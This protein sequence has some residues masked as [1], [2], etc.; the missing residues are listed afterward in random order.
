MKYVIKFII[1]F[2]L[3]FM[4]TKSRR[5]KYERKHQWS[6]C[7]RYICCRGDS[8]DRL[9]RDIERP[10]KK[11]QNSL[12]VG[13]P[14]PALSPQPVQVWQLLTC[15]FLS[16]T[17]KKD[18]MKKDSLKFYN[19]VK[20]KRNSAQRIS[21]SAKDRWQTR[22]WSMGRRNVARWRLSDSSHHEIRF[23]LFMFIE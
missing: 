4:Q 11:Y 3:M 22:L 9:H 20:F 12:N 7:P 18:C 19:L 10:K 8:Q 23:L 15:P 5:V 21:K 6:W 2:N 1:Y 13:W 14:P 16:L 17:E